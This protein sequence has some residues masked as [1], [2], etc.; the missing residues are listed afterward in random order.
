LDDSLAQIEKRIEDMNDA[1]EWLGR[2]DTELKSLDKS[3][4]DQLKLTKSMLDK[5][6]KKSQAESK[7]GP[8]PQIRDNVVRLKRQGWTID[9]IAES[10]KLSK[11]EVELILETA[12]RE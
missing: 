9:E 6:G 11:G 8:P 1:R 3:I 12:P 4:R 5:E 10:L 2:V 7:G